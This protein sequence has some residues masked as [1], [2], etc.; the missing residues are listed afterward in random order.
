MLY[1]NVDVDHT[2]G[3]HSDK[4]INARFQVTLCCVQYAKKLA[5]E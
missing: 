4:V 1:K 2:C 3:K 5:E